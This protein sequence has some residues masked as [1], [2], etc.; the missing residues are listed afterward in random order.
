MQHG[1]D[2]LAEN[3]NTVDF[4]LSHSPATSELRLMGGQGLYETDVL[5]DYLDEVKARVDYKKHFFGHMHVNQAIDDK[6]ICLYEQIVR[7]L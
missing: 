4:I 7:I 5:T 6:D 2:V 1:Y 3:N